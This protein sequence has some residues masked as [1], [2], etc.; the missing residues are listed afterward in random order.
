MKE[1]KYVNEEM[2]FPKELVENPYGYITSWA[3]S[4][5]PH[6]GRK[7]FEVLSLMPCSLIIPDISYEGMDIRSNINCLFLGTSGCGKTTI[8]EMFKSLTYSPIAV[9]SITAPRLESEIKKYEDA[10][11]II[12]DLARMSRDI[13]VMK[14]IEGLLGEEK[15]TSRMTMRSESMEKK[16]LIGLMCGVPSDMSS[17]F[18]SGILFRTFPIVL[19]HSQKQHSEIGG[20]INENIGKENKGVKE[21]E[22]EIKRYYQELSKIHI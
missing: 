4:I 6:T 16:N 21:K 14:V 13:K 20:Y 11:L 7:I 3:E 8:T 15:S 2:K 9:N 10:T 18:S 12:G 5:L 19:F 22:K 17:H 1:S